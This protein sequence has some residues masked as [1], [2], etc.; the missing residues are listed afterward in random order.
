V[1]AVAPWHAFLVSESDS[2]QI[3]GRI[4]DHRLPHWAGPGKHWPGEFNT[5]DGGLD[6]Y[7]E[8]PS[9]HL[10]EIIIRHPCPQ[11]RPHGS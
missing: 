3:F 4:R 8:D 6:V 10:L 5:Y 11:A 7:W 9:G 1:R 2:D